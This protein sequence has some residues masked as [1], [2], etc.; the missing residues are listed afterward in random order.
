MI[1]FPCHC[2]HEFELPEEMAGGLMQCPHCGRLND[3]PTLSDLANLGVDG[4]YNMESTTST[5]E[6]DRMSQLRRAFTR[7]KNDPAGSPIDLLPT[8][9]DVD[10]VGS[11]DG[12]LSLSDQVRPGAPKY[13]PET[14]ELVR[15]LNV[16]PMDLPDESSIPIAGRSIGYT[17]EDL[18]SRY[19]PGRILLE[20]LFP[21]NLVVML[22][23]LLAHVV[24]QLTLYII[25]GWVVTLAIAGLIMAHY[26]TVVEEIGPEDRDELPRPLRNASIGDDL[27]RPFCHF[28]LSLALCY[29][30]MVAAWYAGVVLHDA[31]LVSLVPILFGLGGFVF[32]AVLMTAITSGAPLA[33]L[34][35]DRL[36]SVIRQCGGGYLVSVIACLLASGLYLWLIV[37]LEMIPRQWLSANPWLSNLNHFVVVYLLIWIAIY[38]VH[39][40]AWHLGLLYRRHHERFNWTLQRH[41]P[42]NR[43]ANLPQEVARR[44]AEAQKRAAP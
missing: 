27:W 13:D 11:D 9:D 24:A 38:G 22:F 32:P 21:V 36:L 7:Q 35:P 34:R 19:T 15:P 44:H 41:I 39:F 6:A 5:A 8:L 1:R 25:F 17:S 4:T 23:V 42:A 16:R 12:P 31:L 28:F 40:F 29:G 20:L 14:G 26:A 3:V 30:P 43:M 2:G 33:N 10:R 18:A 37:G